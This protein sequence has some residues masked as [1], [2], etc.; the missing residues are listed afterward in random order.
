MRPFLVVYVLSVDDAV[1]N[2]SA[3]KSIETVGIRHARG[4]NEYRDAM[5]AELKKYKTMNVICQYLFFTYRVAPKTDISQETHLRCGG[6]FSD[7]I[8]TNVLLI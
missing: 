6:I 1:C 8:I 4:S 3:L 7:I 5:R 2:V